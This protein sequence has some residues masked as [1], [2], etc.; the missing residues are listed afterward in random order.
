MAQSPELFQQHSASLALSFL[1]IFNNDSAV[2]EL[3]TA[4]LY[5]NW[6]ILVE[7]VEA[8]TAQCHE[9]NNGTAVKKQKINNCSLKTTTIILSL[10][11]HFDCKIK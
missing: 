5:T 7:L 9:V 10:L 2:N 3:D 1:V 6:T 8:V 11:R 4:V